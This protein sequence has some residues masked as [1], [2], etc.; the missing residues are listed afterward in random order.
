MYSSKCTPLWGRGSLFLQIK[1]TTTMPIRMVN[2]DPNEQDPEDNGNY[3]NGGGG[4]R[5]ANKIG[6]AHV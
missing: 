4:G 3:D 6:R 2:D 1:N 5:Q